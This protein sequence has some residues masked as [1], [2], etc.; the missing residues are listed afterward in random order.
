MASTSAILRYQK[1]S[2]LFLLLSHAWDQREQTNCRNSYTTL[3]LINSVTPIFPSGMIT[4]N[5]ISQKWHRLR[6]FYFTKPDS[7]CHRFRIPR[8]FVSLCYLVLVWH[9]PY[10]FS[11]QYSQRPSHMIYCTIY[12]FIVIRLRS[13]SGLR[14]L[15]GNFWLILNETLRF[16]NASVVES[17]AIK[18]LQQKTWLVI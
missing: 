15:D 12:P 11:L 13:V 18:S 5:I 6:W 3:Q 9:W 7:I 14:V 16:E 2:Q 10:L 8:P 4:S 17:K 1:L